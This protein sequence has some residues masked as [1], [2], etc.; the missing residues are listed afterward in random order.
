MNAHNTFVSPDSV[1][2]RSF[3]ALTSDRGALKLTLP[4]KAI[5]MIALGD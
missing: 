1:E 5:V 4:A 3:R 2:P